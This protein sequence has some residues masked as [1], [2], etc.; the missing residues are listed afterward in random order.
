[1]L[2]AKAKTS[3]SDRA[4]KLIKRALRNALEDKSLQLQTDIHPEILFR[5]NSINLLV[6]RRGVGKTFN[7]LKELI[8]L[9]Q[10]PGNAGFSTFL[11]VSDKVNDSTVNELIKLV[12]LK[13]RQVSYKNV[14]SVLEDIIDA[15]SAYGDVLEK[16]LQEEISD[17]T[18]ADLFGTLDIDE[19][20]DD[21]PH[22]AVLLDDAINILKEPK[23]KGLQNL[24]F[25]NRQPRLTIFICVQDI[26]GVP[27]KIRRNCDAIW[28]FAGMIDR[29]AFGIM[30]AQLGLSAKELWEP[31]RQL[32]PRG[33]MIVEY[34]LNGE[35][36]RW[37]APSPA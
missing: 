19:W 13:V 24:L 6:A 18:R 8:K 22:T 10:L 5:F 37:M 20:W 32:P 16:G 30:C 26:F 28:V 2:D 12:K 35:S 3:L 1:M 36:I 14:Q 17:K 27:I 7:V 33:A 34:G 15:K 29:M 4:N 23:F 31:Y 25:Q 9:S 11:Y 21:I